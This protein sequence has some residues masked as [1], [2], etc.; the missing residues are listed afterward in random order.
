MLDEDSKKQLRSYRMDALTAKHLHHG[1]LS[2][3]RKASLIV[4][5]LAVGVPVL[6]FAFRFTAKGTRAQE[7]TEFIWEFLAAALSV[8]AILKLSFRW[9]D[10]IEKHS[11]LMAENNWLAVKARKLLD[12]ANSAQRKD[13]DQ[14][15]EQ[16]LELEDEDRRA[17]GDVPEQKKQRAY[18]EAL[19]DFDPDGPAH[20]PVCGSSAYSFKPGSCQVCGN[21][22]AK[23]G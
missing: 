5:F 15:I 23:R 6:Y 16:A 1:R 12:A 17:L 14:F 4:D 21:T 18:R 3:R 22:P 9:E 13:Y 19:K 2:R 11:K 8:L 20:C 7:V 10:Y